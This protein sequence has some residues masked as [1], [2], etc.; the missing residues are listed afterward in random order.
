MRSEVYYNPAF[1]DSME[2]TIATSSKEADVVFMLDY[3]LV[4]GGKRIGFKVL[5]FKSARRNTLDQKVNDAIYAFTHAQ[6][7][8][9]LEK[10]KCIILCDSPSQEKMGYVD[11]PL[12]VAN[13]IDIT[14]SEAST[15]IAELCT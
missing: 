12:S 14:K 15:K 3:Y 11:R 6:Q 9:M 2:V 7:V 13:V 8:G 1:E 5:R 10:D 4:Q